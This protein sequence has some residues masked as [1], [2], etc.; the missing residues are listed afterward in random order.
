VKRNDYFDIS[1]I[2]DLKHQN[3]SKFQ[4]LIYRYIVFPTRYVNG[5]ILLKNAGT[6]TSK[7]LKG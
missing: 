3:I 7:Y 4:N 5:Q 6:F 2:S 1:C